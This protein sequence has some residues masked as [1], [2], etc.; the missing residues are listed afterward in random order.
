[1]AKKQSRRA[2][3]RSSSGSM[4]MGG[5]GLIRFYQDESSKVKVGPLATILL[6]V[7]LIVLVIIGHIWG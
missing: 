5:A 6:S 4:P 1:M 7:A 2:R 3:R